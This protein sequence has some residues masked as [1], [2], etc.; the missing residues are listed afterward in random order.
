MIKQLAIGLLLI[1]GTAF[2]GDIKA[3]E[4]KSKP[5]IACHGKT[6]KSTVSVYPHINGQ[7]EEYLKKQLKDFRDGQRTNDSGVMRSM[8]MS[9]SDKDIADIAAYFASQK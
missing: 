7:Q 1:S 5:C 2:A 8:T 6:G 9:L 4:E 3:G